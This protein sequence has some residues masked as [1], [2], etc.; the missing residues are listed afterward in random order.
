MV[1]NINARQVISLQ[2]VVEKGAGKGS[3]FRLHDGINTLGRDTSNRVKLADPKVSRHHCK[4]R[5]V[6]LSVIL[7]DLDAR[8]GTSINGKIVSECE[9]NVGDR[10]AVG[11]TILRLDDDYTPGPESD[12][13]SAPFSFFQKITMAFSGRRREEAPS[14][15]EESYEFL[16]RNRKAIWKAPPGKD[17]PENRR[18]ALLS[19]DPDRD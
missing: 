18:K 15:I 17:A 9:I 5:K 6:G 2:I 1:A 12:Q 10:I 19:T 8:N 13:P 4:I 7:C 16:K 3:V 14:G 11:A